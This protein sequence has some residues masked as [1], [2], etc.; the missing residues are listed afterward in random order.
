MKV[1][2]ISIGQPAPV[3]SLLDQ[4]E[5]QI[6]LEDLRG[7]KILLSFHPLAWTGVCEIQMRT[8][9]VKHDS[10]KKLNVVALGISVDSVPSKKAWAGSMGIKETRLL[11]DFQ[12]RGAVADKYGLFLDKH[13]FSRRANILIDEAGLIIF[14][15]IY[16]LGDIPDI[17]E[18][19][20]FIQSA[21]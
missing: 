7:K 21:A 2:K 12:P 6:N 3:F 11:A 10:L 9:E 5:N 20:R 8:L 16:R 19:L 17:E 4:D 18:I 15:K 13:G 14:S 1:A